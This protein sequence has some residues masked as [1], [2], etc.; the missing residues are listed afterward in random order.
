MVKHLNRLGPLV[1]RAWFWLAA[2]TD[3]MEEKRR[4]VE[5][6]LELNPE[7]QAACAHGGERRRVHTTLSYMWVRGRY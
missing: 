5:A 4:C 7:S 2:E 6:V 3:G 1:I